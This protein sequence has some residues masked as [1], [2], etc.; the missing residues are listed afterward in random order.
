[1]SSPQQLPDDFS[2]IVRLFPLGELVAFP[3]NVLPLHIF[4]SRYREMF[5][6]A[7]AG[8]QLI[9]MAT[10]VPG[11]SD[12]YFTRPPVH[13]TICIGRIMGHET[14]A[15]GTYEFL[16]LG[17]ARARI[18]NEVEPIRSFRE[19]RVTLLEDTLDASP[20]EQQ[21][22]MNSLT[23]VLKD[24]FPEAE[25]LLDVIASGHFELPALTDFLAF[26]LPLSTDEKLH[27]LSETSV[28]RRALKLLQHCE[29][30]H[31][32]TARPSSPGEGRTGFPDFSN[33]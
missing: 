22:L 6:D 31:S 32:R 12:E 28:T 16:L 11:H 3:S 33:N 21:D 20:G 10:L 15:K 8:D 26:Q 23:S 30:D 17:I 7:I 29:R 25:Q 4:E 18:E 1:M 9:A 24:R 2:N 5:E 13:P 27:L 19:A 14:T